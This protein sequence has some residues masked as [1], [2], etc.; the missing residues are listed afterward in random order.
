MLSYSIVDKACCTP[1][2]VLVAVVRDFVD[3][4]S[5]LTQV[6]AGDRAFGPRACPFRVVVRESS[7]ECMICA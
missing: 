6:G 1:D 5:K 3:S 4:V 7:S 2:V